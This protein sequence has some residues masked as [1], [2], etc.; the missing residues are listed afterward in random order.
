MAPMHALKE[1]IEN[2]VDAG[3]T[4]IEVL[5]KDGGLKLLQITDNGHGI[6]VSWLALDS[7]IDMDNVTDSF[8]RDDLPI[9][10]E[11]FTT[12]KLKEFEDLSSIGTYGFR[13]EALASISHIA[14]LTVTTKTAGSSCAWRAHYADGKLVPAKPGQNAAPKATAGRGGTQITVTTTA[15]FRID[16]VLT[17]ATGRGLVLQ[18]PYSP[19]C[20][21]LRERRV[22][23]DPRCCWSICRALLW[24]CLLMSQAWRLGS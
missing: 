1:L 7:P 22:R 16:K 24:R 13:G 18:C 17:E 14:H 3:S 19:P 5:I 10:C 11:R 20:V 4:S 2:A 23:Q 21:S 6:D 12:S 9:L 15:C 8:Q